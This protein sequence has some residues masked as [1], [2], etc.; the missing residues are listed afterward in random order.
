[1]TFFLERAIS[2]TNLREFKYLRVHLLKSASSHSTV[3]SDVKKNLGLCQDDVQ[4]G[5]S[6]KKLRDKQWSSLH[7]AKALTENRLAQRVCGGKCF[8]LLSCIWELV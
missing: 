4:H 5:A 7:S 2:V 3:Q 8:L 1:M 6:G